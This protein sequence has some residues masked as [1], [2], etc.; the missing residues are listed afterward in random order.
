MTDRRTWRLEIDMLGRPLL[1][2]AA[3]KMHFQDRDRIRADWR[4]AT[5]TLARA[6]RIPRCAAID[7]KVQ[8]R[9]R[10]RRTPGDIDSPAP[11]VKGVIDGLVNAG[12]IRDDKPPYIRSLLYVTPQ[13]GTG[14]PDAL[15]VWITDTTPSEAAA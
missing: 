7:I 4:D 9:Y 10:T 15:I 14:L 11:T 3:N 2:N 8:A 1:A 12:I 13:I 6:Q 5:T